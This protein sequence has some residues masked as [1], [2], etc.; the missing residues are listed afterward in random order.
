ML[1]R[2][3]LMLRKMRTPFCSFPKLL[4]TSHN[5]LPIVTSPAP[6]GPKVFRPILP[7][8]SPP[9][10]P[11]HVRLPIT[12]VD[13][14]TWLPHSQRAVRPGIITPAFGL[15]SSTLPCPRVA[16]SSSLIK[17][18]SHQAYDQVTTNVRFKMIV[19]IVRK[20][21][22]QHTTGRRGRRRPY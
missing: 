15:A 18:Q 13:A 14:T 1:P 21:Q 10:S 12:S 20:S 5:S 16:N 2:V 22:K 6:A 8:L 9:G 7:S 3:G 11:P 19:R 4:L 17:R